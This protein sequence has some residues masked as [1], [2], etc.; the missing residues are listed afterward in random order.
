[1]ETLTEL[2][3]GLPVA[4]RAPVIEVVDLATL[5]RQAGA[6]ALG[7]VH[8]S[9]THAVILVTR[10]R[11]WHG[12]DFETQPCSPGTLVRV[13]PGQAQQFQV[14]S[15]LG[16]VQIRFAADVPAPTGPET[17]GRLPDV[18]G[19]PVG[20]RLTS[21]EQ[22]EV[23]GIVDS[24]AAEH[25]QTGAAHHAEILA[26]LLLAT[27][28]EPLAAL[29]DRLGFGDAAGLGRFFARHAGVAPSVFRRRYRDD[30]GGGRRVQRVRGGAG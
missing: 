20:S 10:G 7:A 25:A 22:T 23:G 8:R 21:V 14:P 5:R 24:P 26:H 3:G 28:D 6:A 18:R 29:G 13:R 1:L 16:G 11:G 27:T 12:V 30:S 19:G 15:R 9:D 4:G 2:G 17:L